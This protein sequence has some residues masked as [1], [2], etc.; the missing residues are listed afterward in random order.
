MAWYEKP[1]ELPTETHFWPTSSP[2][3]G[4]TGPRKASAAQGNW[5]RCQCGTQDGEEMSLLLPVHPSWQFRKG[6]FPFGWSELR[7]RENLRT[8]RENSTSPTPEGKRLPPLTRGRAK[9]Q[10]KACLATKPTLLIN[11]GIYIHMCLANW[12]GGRPGVKFAWGLWRVERWKREE[13][14]LCM[15]E[16]KVHWEDSIVCF[17]HSMQPSLL[18]WSLSQREKQ[19]GGETERQ[20]WKETVSLKTLWAL[21]HK[22]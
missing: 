2:T 15:S 12:P 13:D 9:I 21:R 11:H 6:L 5:E 20:K 7:E 16:K 19:R 4:S 3:P 18:D 17:P 22:I 1:V 10:T 14:G 8:F